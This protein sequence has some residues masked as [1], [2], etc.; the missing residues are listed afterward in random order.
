MIYEARKERMN[1]RTKER[2][3]DVERGSLRGK[4]YGLI[5]PTTVDQGDVS[6]HCPRSFPIL[7][8]GSRLSSAES[9]VRF[10]SSLRAPSIR[11]TF[12]SM[13]RNKTRNGRNLETSAFPESSRRSVVHGRL[14]DSEKFLAQEQLCRNL[15]RFL[16]N[17]SCFKFNRGI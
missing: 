6:C 15:N 8:S 13:S 12:L 10:C 4:L 14:T 2:K 16:R 3:K 17:G 11:R 5:K 1:E 7:P 9:I